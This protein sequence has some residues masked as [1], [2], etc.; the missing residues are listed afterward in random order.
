MPWSKPISRASSRATANN[1]GL[2]SIPIASPCLPTRLAISRVIAPLP[3][4]TSRTRSPAAMPSKP[5]YVSRAATSSAAFARR[6]RRAARSRACSSVAAAVSRQ[7]LSAPR[8]CMDLLLR[9]QHVVERLVR[10]LRNLPT[11]DG[12][13]PTL[14]QRAKR[15]PPAVLI[16]TLVGDAARQHQ[17][18][19]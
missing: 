6:S 18:Q 13:L 15:R 4:P 17:E 14:D 7:R 19:R 9:E 5:R 12:G 10:I 3:Q 8:S 1:A 2:G 11:G 16:D